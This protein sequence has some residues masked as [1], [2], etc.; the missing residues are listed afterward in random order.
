MTALPYND[1]VAR[2]VASAG[3]ATLP[4]DFWIARAD[5]LGVWRVRAGVATKLT[6]GI[7]YTVSGI[8]SDAGGSVT[9]TLPALALDAYILAGSWQVQQVLDLV[10]SGDFKADDVD[11]QHRLILAA[12][13]EIRRD[14]AR[15]LGV[16]IHDDGT[17]PFV[18]NARPISGLTYLELNE[19]GTPAAATDKARLYAKDVGGVTKLYLRTGTQDIDLTAG[20]INVSETTAAAIADAAA[21][22]ASAAQAAAD[23]AETAAV[24]EDWLEWVNGEISIKKFGAKVDGVTDDTAAWIAAAEAVK[25]RGGGIVIMPTGTSIVHREAIS[26]DPST[27]GV[28]AVPI[29]FDDFMVV[30]GG[31]G[32]SVIK[33][34]E[35]GQ[36]GIFQLI[37]LPLENGIPKIYRCGIVNVELDGNYSGS[38]IAGHPLVLGAGLVDFKFMHNRVRNNGHYGLGLQNGGHQGCEIAHCT[39]ENLWRDAV[40]HKDNVNGSTV[41]V[42]R[43]NK[44]H[45]I[46]LRN[47]CRGNLPTT[48][49]AM[50]DVMGPGWMIHDVH[51]EQ[52]PTDADATIDAVVRIKPG[53]DGDAI[54]RGMGA[55]R[56]QVFA[57]SATRR[58]GDA[59]LNTVV[60]V[61]APY[62]N[63]WGVS[64]KGAFTSGVQVSQA[65][66][67]VSGCTIDGATTGV[68]VRAI[69]GLAVDS[70]PFPGADD[71]EIVNNRILNCGTA[72]DNV[73]GRIKIALNRI[74]GNTTGVKC[75]TSTAVNPEICLNTFVSNTTDLD[76]DADR[77]PLI[78]GNAGLDDG[79]GIKYSPTG[80]AAGI[81]YHYTPLDHRF[82]TGWDGDMASLIEAL[83]VVHVASAVNYL[84]VKP[85]VAGS[86]V[87]I[88]AAGD[89]ANIDLWMRPK[90]SGGLRIGPYAS[91]VL[92]PT[93]YVTIKDSSG[94]DRRV[95]TG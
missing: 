66:C 30:G 83:R 12:L 23:A 46:T 77:D 44:I 75:S 63:V 61:R 76:F 60:N 20:A 86:P 73:R 58:V 3:A 16:A 64:A 45:H 15:T 49:L 80:S 95:L 21:A 40:D 29:D 4:Y 17:G 87:E 94:T 92:S 62:V 71:C 55:Q 32:P 34:K 59:A 1:R 72:I 85:S 89:D 52:M 22:A 68:K 53:V 57:I 51:C 27:Y 8:G 10:T 28:G 36:Y 82:M 70:H 47:V 13:M 33:C 14:L 88:V 54:G 93:G 39:F 42:G 18:A 41:S 35:G 67:S 7:D 38:G 65:F 43:E 5:D 24:A 50:I 74:A 91:G 37:K 79:P 48:P 69:E 84:Q 9:L 19:T 31:P 78:W 2:V 11:H 25:A 90:G 56:G 26:T 81:A 6:L